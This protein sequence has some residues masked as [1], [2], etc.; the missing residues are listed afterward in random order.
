MEKDVGGILEKFVPE[1]T[2]QGRGPGAE[3]NARDWKNLKTFYNFVF[4]ALMK[5]RFFFNPQNAPQGE[6]IFRTP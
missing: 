3:K 5:T 6:I 1:L 2:G 4:P